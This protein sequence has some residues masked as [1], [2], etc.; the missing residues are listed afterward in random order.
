MVIPEFVPSMGKPPLYIAKRLIKNGHEVTILTS[1]MDLADRKIRYEVEELDGSKTIRMRGFTF[2]KVNNKKIIIP[3]IFFEFLSIIFRRKADVVY[4][5]GLGNPSCFFAALISKIGG[6]PIVL[7]A[8]WGGAPIIEKGLKGLY[9]RCVKLPT[10]RW[11]DKILVFSKRQKEM[12]INYR[13]DDKKIE[14]VPNGVDCDTFFFARK[15]DYLHKRLNLEENIKIIAT[16]CRLTPG[17]NPEFAI[18][19]LANVIK[20]YSDVV[21]VI[22]G[23]KGN[24]EYY[25][26]LTS[27]IKELGLENKAFFLLEINHEDMPQIYSSADIFF[28]TSRP[29][30]GMN[31]SSIEAMCAGLPIITTEVSVT[32]EIVEE[33]KC[34]YVIKSEDDAAEKIMCLLTH[35]EERKKL[36]ENGRAYV[37][38]NLSWEV[39]TPKVEELMLNLFSSRKS[40]I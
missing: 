12:M 25:D 27:T 36:G 8:D 35:E 21:L 20:S 15:S 9:D 11:S 5:D 30:E 39:L 22:V 29:I 7:R 18:R 34:G 16:V 4:A 24:L 3:K 14:V 28:L 37:K 19:T 40:E 2:G 13:I 23:Y 6:V 38:S 1:D 32:P 17:K 31:L 10:L 33:A 26:H